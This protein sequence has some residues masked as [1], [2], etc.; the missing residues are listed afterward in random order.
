MSVLP[1][2]SRMPVPVGVVSVEE[3]VNPL[4][5]RV[6]WLAVMVIAEPLVTLILVVR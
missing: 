6:T 4:R 1:L 2:A 3:S 5:S